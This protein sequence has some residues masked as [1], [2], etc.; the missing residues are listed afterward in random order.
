MAIT[1]NGTT[2]ITTPALDTSGDVTFADNDKA[3]FGAGSDLQIFHD[4]INSY[5]DDAGNGDMLIRGSARILLRKAGTTE[6]MIH[7]EAD[8]YVKLFYDNAEKLATTA[9]GIDV[10]GTIIASNISDGTTSVPS[11]YVVNG[12]AKAWCRA[13][14]TGSQSIV[15]SFNTSTITDYALGQTVITMAS[16][17]S[18]GDY[19][20]TGSITTS[21]F[22]F[23]LTGQDS[24]SFRVICR[25]DAAVF[26]DTGISGFA[27]GDLA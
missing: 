12:S 26:V 19:A 3:I 4:G 9:T 5:I 15:S 24:T 8:S 18:D 2:G 7:A 13:D 21:R 22:N 1:L 16:A 14:Q 25:D 11:T 20:G 27:F 23:S 17:M 10:T 6:N